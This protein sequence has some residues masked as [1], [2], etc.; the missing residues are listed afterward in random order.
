VS[1]SAVITKIDCPKCGY[2]LIEVIK[3]NPWAPIRYPSCKK[4]IGYYT[5]PAGKEIRKMW[6]RRNINVL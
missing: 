1:S 6:D 2:N 5:D 3:G 4:L